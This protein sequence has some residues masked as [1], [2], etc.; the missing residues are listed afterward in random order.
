LLEVIIENRSSEP[1]ALDAV[2]VRA[3]QKNATDCGRAGSREGPPQQVTF[4]WTKTIDGS[5]ASDVWTTIGGTDVAAQ[6]ELRLRGCGT[7]TFSA[8]IPIDHVVDAGQLSRIKLLLSEPPDS[9]TLNVIQQWS[10]FEVGLLPGGTVLPETVSVQRDQ[11]IF[12]HSP[13]RPEKT[14]GETGERSR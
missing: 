4:A 12:P 7:D 1:I 8:T 9:R 14:N 5:K 6:A 10:A 2:T 13:Q 3:S 11:S